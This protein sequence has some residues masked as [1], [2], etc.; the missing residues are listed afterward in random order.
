MYIRHA[1]AFFTLKKRVLGHIGTNCA[2][3]AKRRWRIIYASEA[4]IY[5]KVVI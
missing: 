1:M 2:S 3:A 4:K 5:P